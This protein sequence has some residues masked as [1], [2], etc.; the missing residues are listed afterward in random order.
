MAVLTTTEAKTKLLSMIRKA[1]EL[2]EK[3]VIT[4]RGEEFA[5]LLGNEDYEGLLETIDIL[6]NNKEIKNIKESLKNLRAGETYS[7]EQVV[8]RKQKK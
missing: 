2:G 3:Y 6:Q 5:I 4:H 8:G 1:H 7:F